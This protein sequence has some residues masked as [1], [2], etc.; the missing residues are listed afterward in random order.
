MFPFECMGPLD[1]HAKKQIPGSFCRCCVVSWPSGVRFGVV[2]EV[3]G[4]CGSM[5]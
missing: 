1:D 3:S 4:G 2:D 5:V